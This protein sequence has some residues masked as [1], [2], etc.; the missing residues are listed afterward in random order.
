MPL[1]VS[2]L[3]RNLERKWR[4]VEKSHKWQRKKNQKR[5]VGAPVYA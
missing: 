4:K 1:G 5:F 2:P 3:R